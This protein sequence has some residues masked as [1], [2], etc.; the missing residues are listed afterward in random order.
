MSQSREFS[1][2]LQG[3]KVRIT[4]GKKPEYIGQ[5]ATIT[6][7]GIFDDGVS[8][9]IGGNNYY[10]LN[11]GEYELI[12]ESYGNES[13]DWDQYIGKSGYAKMKAQVDDLSDS[14]KK[15]D[16][17]SINEYFTEEQISKPN[18]DEELLSRFK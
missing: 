10:L 14:N 12:G 15:N 18:N 11:K 8:V 5:T 2:D 13:E 7:V 16:E 6:S 4:G 1:P 9:N 3:K 17:E